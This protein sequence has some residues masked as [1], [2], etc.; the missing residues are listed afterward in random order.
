MQLFSFG[1]YK[2]NENGTRVTDADGLE[3]PTYTTRDIENFAKVW[4]GLKR[5]GSRSNIELQTP[6]S[7][8][9]E[10]LKIN[11][12]YRDHTPKTDLRGGYLGD[13]VQLCSEMPLKSF[14]RVGAK[15]QFVSC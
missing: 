9:I 13:N 14:L 3:F 11:R 15:Y 6:P 10:P 2:L 8:S 4:T 1:L 5:R 12:N 7:N